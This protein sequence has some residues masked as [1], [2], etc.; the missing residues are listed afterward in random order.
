MTPQ[1]SEAGAPAD[2]FRER[3][4][5]ASVELIQ[6]QGLSA[7][8]MREVARRAG[9]SHQAPYYY[10]EDREAILAAIAE[11]GFR[12][13]RET[14]MGAITPRQGDSLYAGIVAAGEAYIR[15]A[16]AN[17]A[18][19]RLMFRPELVSPLRHPSMKAEG[20]RACSSF[21]DIV[22][23]AVQAGLPADPSLDA[24][25]LLYW[26]IGHGFACLA[27]DGPL[28]AV[29]PDGNR[30]Q[31]TRDL[32]SAFSKLIAGG[33]GQSPARKTEMP[34]SRRAPRKRA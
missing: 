15:F 22:R 14:V 13:L 4:V 20:D 32:L 11:Q 34:K 17:P 19:F 25:F 30:E 16:F 29:M 31:Q 7:L 6:E 27:L 21:Y 23:A 8:S 28:D 5:Q 10:F 1:K 12:M 3:I 33:L 18:Y 2:A 9:V 24:L 26:S